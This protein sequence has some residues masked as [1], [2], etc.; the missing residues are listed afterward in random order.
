MRESDRI[1]IRE[2]L[3]KL[4][5]SLAWSSGMLLMVFVIW[6][7]FEP[8]T[9]LSLTLALFVVSGLVLRSFICLSNM[10]LHS[11]HLAFQDALTAMVHANL[12]RDDGDK[13]LSGGAAVDDAIRSVEDLFRDASNRNPTTGASVDN[14]AGSLAMRFLAGQALN[15]VCLTAAA[16]L[17]LYFSADVESLVTSAAQWVS[18]LR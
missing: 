7:S 1:E 10:A 9:S 14:S 8:M 17:G 5:L 18:A 2:D 3:D 16:A 12:L 15:L 6:A 13:Y 11:R 4:W